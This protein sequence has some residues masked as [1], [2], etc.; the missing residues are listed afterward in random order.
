MNRILSGCRFGK[1]L[2]ALLATALGTV[3]LHAPLARAQAPAATLTQ[4]SSDPF[5]IGP[6]Q[7]ATERANRG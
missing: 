6:G 7:H 5:T 3:C 1:T 4:I 2:S